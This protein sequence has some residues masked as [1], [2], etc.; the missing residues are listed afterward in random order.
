VKITLA[1]RH[2]GVHTQRKEAEIPGTLAD[3]ATP[4]GPRD[5]YSINEDK[6][7]AALPDGFLPVPSNRVLL[8]VEDEIGGTGQRGLERFRNWAKYFDA[9]CLNLHKPSDGDGTGQDGDG[10]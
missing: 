4:N 6:L 7:L 8:A 1:H 3:Y 5:D 2:Y 10:Q 9:Y